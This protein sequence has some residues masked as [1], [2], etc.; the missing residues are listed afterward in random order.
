[1]HPGQD[2]GCLKG[3][4][5]EPA[6]C[7]A[8]VAVIPGFLKNM[9]GCSTV[10]T[11][12]MLWVILDLSCWRFCFPHGRGSHRVGRS[13]LKH[14]GARCPN[15]VESSR[16]RYNSRANARGCPVS[17]V[18]PQ[19]PHSHLEEPGRIGRGGEDWVGPGSAVLAGTE[20][21]LSVGHCDTVVLPHL[22]AC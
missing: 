16:L 4:Q 19:C 6:L 11:E 21:G 22:T 17:L 10:W 3:I 14:C 15:S 1:M 9:P 5:P 2:A 7:R 12:L 18:G 13:G 8:N 20:L